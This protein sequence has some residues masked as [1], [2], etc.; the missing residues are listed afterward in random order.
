MLYH[1]FVTCA[2][3]G[4][5]NYISGPGP[6]L[7]GRHDDL[8]LGT[9][10][11]IQHCRSCGYSSPAIDVC[12]PETAAFLQRPAYRTAEQVGFPH[13]IQQPFFDGEEEIERI[14]AA[15]SHYQYALQLLWSGETENAYNAFL[16]AAWNCDSEYKAK[17]KGFDECA[18]KCRKRA[19][20]LYDEVIKSLGEK[21]RKSKLES[22]IIM[23]IDTLRRAGCFAEAIRFAGNYTDDLSLKPLMDYQISLCQAQD[24][25]RHEQKDVYDYVA[26]HGDEYE[27]YYEQHR[28]ELEALLA[29][30]KGTTDDTE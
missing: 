18:K 4:K 6:C 19:A 1:K 16:N 21:P 2:V 15:E 5:R 22:I 26:A 23:Q 27:A 3:C 14:P 12:E 8:D 7:I 29:E 11:P 30:R 28:A 10:Y 20:G 13:E 24:D 25:G 17:E 9:P